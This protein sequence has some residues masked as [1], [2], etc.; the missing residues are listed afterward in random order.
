MFATSSSPI[1]DQIRLPI[2]RR[3]R[4]DRQL[5]LFRRV[6]PAL[7][8]NGTGESPGHVGDLRAP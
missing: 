7:E 5:F 2:L 3:R 4:E 1:G 6:Q 8:G